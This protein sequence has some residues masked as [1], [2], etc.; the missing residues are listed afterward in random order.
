[1][2]M[3]VI[4]VGLSSYNLALFHLVNHAFYKAL[5][6]LGAGA[7]IHA[8]S[9]NQDFR[10]YGGLR[11]FL[12]L[13]YSVMLIASLSLVAFPFMTGFYSKDF[14]LESAYG[15][16]YF[17]STVVYFIATIGA[18]FTTLYS[19][20]VLYL[21]FLTNPNGPLVNYKNAHEGG[22]FMSLPLVVLATFSIFFGYVTKDIFI[23]LGSGFFA[24]NSLFIH[25]NHE[26]MLDTE[27]AVSTFYKL[28]PLAFTVS[29]TVLSLIISEYLPK[30]LIS[31][32]FTRLGYNVFSFFNQRFLI[33]LFYNKYITGL[34]LKLGG[35][36]TKVLDK[37]SIELIGPFGLEKGLLSLSKNLSSLDTGVV[38][39]YALYI[40]IGLITY[41]LVPYL[42]LNDN[43]LL[44]LTILGI[45]RYINSKPFS[46]IDHEQIN[47]ITLN[48]AVLNL[49]DLNI[50]NII[51]KS[52]QDFYSNFTLKF[53]IKLVV[54][55]FCFKFFFLCLSVIFLSIGVSTT[56]F[57]LCVCIFIAIYFA[58][59][60]YIKS[61]TKPKKVL[62]YVLQLAISLITLISFWYLSG[63]LFMFLGLDVLQVISIVPPLFW[64]DYQVSMDP[65][66]DTGGI[67]GSSSNFNSEFRGNYGGGGGGGEPQGPASAAA[68]SSFASANSE[69]DLVKL[70]KHLLNKGN[71]FVKYLSKNDIQSEVTVENSYVFNCLVEQEAVC[72]I[73]L[74]EVQ[75]IQEKYI[76]AIVKA[77]MSENPDVNMHKQVLFSNPQLYPTYTIQE[78]QEMY[79]ESLSY[80]G[81]RPI[82]D[83]SNRPEGWD[84]RSGST[85]PT[86]EP[87]GEINALNKRRASPIL[88]ALSE[89]EK[90]HKHG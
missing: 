37:G 10:K 48:S 58:Y 24:D 39:S 52:C 75:V 11:Q 40:L 20:K 88:T 64:A 55:S 86:Q 77:E 82:Y 72:N 85:T 68:T 26:I 38:T 69:S 54:I 49:S 57:S 7:V 70:H 29:L 61:G 73:K 31:F 28:L 30:L 16:F 27:F 76:N 19:V 56:N 41:I 90:K 3:M 65:G 83:P 36:T 47:N 2:G 5:L 23:G 50:L 14:I 42:S 43:N 21:T 13:T 62:Y 1:M 34:V 84:A 60:I 53:F 15:Q 35:Q 12:P 59:V 8:V 51:F 25:P 67:G 89:M 4:A 79:N 18:M 71:K 32:K 66:Q 74:F 9:D 81:D 6:F 78:L 46:K 80:K 63:Y 44:L 45:F 33:E 22:I 17:S 87:R